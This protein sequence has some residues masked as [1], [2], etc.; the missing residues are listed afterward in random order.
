MASAIV[1]TRDA[2]TIL[3]GIVQTNEIKQTQLELTDPIKRATDGCPLS[4]TDTGFAERFSFYH[5][6]KAIFQSD[7][8]VWLVWDGKRWNPDPK[9]IFMRDLGMKTAKTILEEIRALPEHMKDAKKSCWQFYVKSEG[10]DRINAGITLAASLGM[11]KPLDVFD[12]DHYALNCANGTVDLKTGDLMPHKKEDFIT[13]LSPVEYDENARDEMFSQFIKS[14]T[15]G[16]NDLEQYLQRACGYSLTGL[17][18]EKC[19]FIVYSEQTDTGKSS[20]VEGIL[21][22]AGDYGL[23]LD[24]ETLLSG[25]HGHNTARYDLAKLQGVRVACVAESA[26][27][28]EFSGEIIKRLTGGDKMR[29]REIHQSSVQF[30]QTHKLWICT[31]YAPAPTDG[32]DEAT[33]NRLR[34][35]PFNHQIPVEQRNPMIKRALADPS[36]QTC[37]ALLT[38]AIQG[39]AM[40]LS[41]QRLGTCKAVE[42]STAEYKSESDPLADFFADCC[43]TNPL[44]Q[45]TSQELYDAYT[46][47]CADQKN[48]YVFSRQRIGRC[49]KLHGFR[50]AQNGLGKMVW[51]GLSLRLPL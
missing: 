42:D 45:V 32:G 3:K 43:E 47:W 36:S 10:R 16:D 20:F 15:N 25:Q 40:W 12:R 13:K 9:L 22:V 29:A 2:V 14:T 17:N 37:R 7:A 1:C 28:R 41:S 26:A 19:L 18:H 38:W 24:I 44:N 49:L 21:A 48:K 4:M 50:S 46:K 27:G 33:W 31:N 23:S 5:K 8:G 35:V 6:D 11:A 34:R 30:D 39:V 51:H